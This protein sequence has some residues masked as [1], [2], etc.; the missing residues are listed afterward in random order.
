M[1]SLTALNFL[2]LALAILPACTLPT[3][4]SYK[5][6][7]SFTTHREFSASQFTLTCTDDLK[8]N[9]ATG[10]MIVVVSTDTPGLWGISRCTA[11]L[12]EQQKIITAGHCSRFMSEHPGSKAF[13][14]TVAR[15]FKASQVSA[16][17]RI[18]KDSVVMDDH[19]SPD[20][21]SLELAT[22]I[23]GIEFVHPARAVPEQMGTVTSLV[24]NPKNS[25]S[26][27]DYVVDAVDCQQ[28]GHFA[29]LPIPY[30]NNPATFVGRNCKIYGG[31]SGGSVF[32]PGDFQSVVGIVDA[33]NNAHTGDSKGPVIDSRRTL[34]ASKDDFALFTNAR[35]LDL[36]GWPQ[37]EKRCLETSAKIAYRLQ[38]EFEAKQV[39]ELI[40]GEG[41]TWSQR[42]QDLVIIGGGMLR[43]E[44]MGFSFFPDPDS[45]D[46]LTL[47]FG[48]LPK[49]KCFEAP[50][51]VKELEALVAV[52]SHGIN[53]EDLDGFIFGERQVAT[54]A[55]KL[56]PVGDDY[57]YMKYDFGL[58]PIRLIDYGLGDIRGDLSQEQ[59]ILIKRCSKP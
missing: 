31:N 13:F 56:R 24:I 54:A 55:L 38:A 46:L 35:C 48:V 44:G 7:D 28:S 18:L 33:S 34:L 42:N 58:P 11:S 41:K 3:D 17:A 19:L 2:L 9:D 43:T 50:A 25:S 21:A 6:K 14:M 23:T 27:Y 57:Y 15:G 59:L 10:I 12:Y 51:K 30:Q 8:C 32:L 5:E 1:K 16:V 4:D 40:T 26:D 36:P 53:G 45:I 52:E 39:D 47:K 29:T 20:F 37:V 49:P 22:P